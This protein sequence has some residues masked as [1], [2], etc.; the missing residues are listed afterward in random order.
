[1]LIDF[2]LAIVDL[3]DFG[4]RITAEGCVFG[5]PVY[6]APEQLA[7]QRVGAACD[8]YALGVLLFELLT[9]RQPFDGTPQQVFTDK[10]RATDGLHLPPSAPHSPAL[11]QLVLQCTNPEA[12]ARP[13]IGAAMAVLDQVS[14]SSARP[15]N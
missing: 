8:V 4:G 12:G 6:M 7:G 2:G 14:E 11:R 15:P 5:T 3:Y 13:S 1:V 10:L 9:G